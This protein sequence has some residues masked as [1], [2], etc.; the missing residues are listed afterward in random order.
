M[1]IDKIKNQAMFNFFQIG[2]QVSTSKINGYR[3]IQHS[4]LS[5]HNTFYMKYIKIGILQLGQST[6]YI[7]YSLTYIFRNYLYLMTVITI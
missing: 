7:S 2:F 1:E 4:L 3:L 5:A 6:Y